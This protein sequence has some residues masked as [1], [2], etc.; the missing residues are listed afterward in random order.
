MPR[1][2]IGAARKR[3]EDQRF[4]TGQGHYLDDLWFE[5]LV[6]AAVLRSPV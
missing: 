1:D 2:G 6:H 3:R 5:G 4:L